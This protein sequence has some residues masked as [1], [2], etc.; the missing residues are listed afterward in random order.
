[1]NDLRDLISSSNLTKTQLV[2]SQF[3]L[4]N[5]SDACFMTSTE[6]AN[7]ISVSESSVIRF[8]R[9]LGFEGFSDFQKYIRREYQDRV[10][11]ISSSITNPAR[12]LQEQAKLGNDSEFLKRHFK[13]VAKNLQAIFVD[14]TVSSFEE[15]A[16]SI[17]GSKNKFII[18][19]RGNAGLGNYFFL[20]LKQMLSGV[21]LTTSSI[22]P[23]DHMCHINKSDCAIIF[24]FP[25]Y[26]KTDELALKM[27]SDAGAKV[28]VITDKP[29]ADLAKYATEILIVRCDSPTFFN[30]LVGAQFIAE[31]L[32][33]TI[34][35]K[36]RSIE[37]RLNYIDNYMSETGDY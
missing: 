32:L 28:V 9:S 26:S 17:I 14:N 12:R 37:K 6:I 24:S 31:A 35:R 25:R 23:I 29:S 10:M 36:T 33:D 7:A 21:E 4:D 22:S 8:S 2:I 16:S 1:M 13:V 15:A 3:I 34:S 19:S 20:Y 11:S 18:A 5:S 27:A 30:S